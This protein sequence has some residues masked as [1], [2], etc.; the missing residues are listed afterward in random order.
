MYVE[1]FE[2]LNQRAVIDRGLANHQIQSNSTSATSLSQPYSQSQSRAPRTPSP[3]FHRAPAPLSLT[4]ALQGVPSSVGDSSDDD[5]DINTSLPFPVP[6]PRSDFLVAGTFDPSTYLSSVV[7]HR[8][9]TLEDLR[10][11]LRT[12]VQNLNTELV[13][14]VNAHQEEFVGL[15]GSLRGGEEKVEEVRVGV[16]GLRREIGDIKAVVE[17]RERDVGRALEERRR[18]RADIE[19]GRAC[20][21]FEESLGVLEGKLGLD[22]AQKKHD[23]EESDSQDSEDDDEDDSG[24]ASIAGVSLAKVDRRVGDLNAIERIA[25]RAGQDHPFIRAQEARLSKCREL[26]LLDLRTC[27]AHLKGSSDA[28]D[29]D[30]KMRVLRLFTEL[31]SSKEAV[32]LLRSSR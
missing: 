23:L 20:L 1:Q 27:L 17:T 16:L 25:S 2:Y 26:L 11:E 28:S 21:E 32:D 3:P 14:L 19:V 22:S 12:R 4:T 5:D 6:L 8:Y 30:H 7:A 18:C 31:K 29:I 15:G 24:G 9:Q 13:E 10:I